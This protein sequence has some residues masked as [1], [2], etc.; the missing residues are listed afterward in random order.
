MYMRKQLKMLERQLKSNFKHSIL[1]KKS[2]LTA[3]SGTS[4]S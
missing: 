1:K 4:K 2:Y 3:Q